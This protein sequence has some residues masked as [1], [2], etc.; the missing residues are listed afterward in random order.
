MVKV[1]SGILL[2]WKLINYYLLNKDIIFHLL[3]LV[4]QRFMDNLHTTHPTQNTSDGKSCH[5]Q[6]R[7]SIKLH[8]QYYPAGR[9]FQTY[10][11]F[12]DLSMNI[13]ASVLTDRNFILC[14]N[15][16][17]WLLRSYECVKVNRAKTLSFRIR[18][19]F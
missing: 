8:F 13:K 6:G 1:Q 11:V 12:T 16:L 5:G 19:V 15:S 7:F 17:V 4:L 14:F 10:G 2:Q 9:I 3:G 18:S